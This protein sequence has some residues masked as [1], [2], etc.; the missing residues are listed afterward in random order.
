MNMVYFNWFPER[1]V[2]HHLSVFHFS[3]L[4]KIFRILF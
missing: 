2:K 4:E 1:K 3:V